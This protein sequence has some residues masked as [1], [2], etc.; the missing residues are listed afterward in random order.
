MAAATEQFSLTDSISDIPRVGAAQ[1][2]LAVERGEDFHNSRTPHRKSASS[3]FYVRHG[4]CV[5]NVGLFVRTVNGSQTCFTLYPGQLLR[6]I[7][8][9]V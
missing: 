1:E 8:A 4:V 9:F 7:Y 6:S 2:P 5:N 3:P